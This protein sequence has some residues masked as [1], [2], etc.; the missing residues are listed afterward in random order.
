MPDPVTAQA[1]EALFDGSPLRG[2]QR[3]LRLVERGRSHDLRRALIAML[4]AWLPLAM[5]ALADGSFLLPGHR[6][7]GVDIGA[8][9]RCLAAIPL[10]ILAESLWVPRVDAI[11]RNFLA[12]GFVP[13]HE[14]KR[15]DDAI[16]ST[17]AW[18][19]SAAAGFA[20]VVL[21]LAISLSLLRLIPESAVPIWHRASVA[22]AV[23]SRAGW[24]H[25]LVS[26]PLLLCLVLGWIW[27]LVLWTRLLAKLARLDL[28]LVASHP[29]GAAGL[30]F[31]GYSVRAAALV[32]MGLSAIVAGSVANHV[33][34][35]GT[36]LAEYRYYVGALVLVVV[37]LVAGPTSVFS[38]RLLDAWRHG[39]FEYG[40]LADRVGLAF[41]R[42]WM[43]KTP[44]EKGSPLEVPDFSATTDLYAI[45]ANVY[46]MQFAPLDL[47]SVVLLILATLLPFVPVVFA[48]APLDDVV[49]AVAGLV[50]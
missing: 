45:V 26:L 30:M 24:W 7:F 20:I 43:A 23:F 32:G 27:R 6:G 46:A 17:L 3:R 44:P 13:D 29:D 40:A 19:D 35:A 2:I 33:V 4:V 9:A 41:E 15:F 31:V 42:R 8:H 50:L 10:L 48:A 39:L 38:R 47:R 28:R 1:S 14:R 22:G 21:A 34:H 25:A 12:G 11:V 16:A 49:K 37:A 36:P 18:R 5:I